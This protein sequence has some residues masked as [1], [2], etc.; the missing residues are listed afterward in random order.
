[1]ALYRA[2]ADKGYAAA[3]FALATA[4]AR[5]VQGTSDAAAAVKLYQSA[6]ENGY[7]KSYYEL[8]ELHWNGSGTAENRKEALRW[9]IRGAERGDPFSHRRLADLYERG[10]EVE[11]ASDKALLHYAI[12]TRLLKDQAD[13]SDAQVV[14]EYRGALARALDP[15]LAVRI[16]RAAQAWKPGSAN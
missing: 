7:L 14:Q 8:G 3:Q 10:E 6:A 13:E 2:G 16:A 5:G 15:L 11:Q 4:Y 12:A 9:F 1:M